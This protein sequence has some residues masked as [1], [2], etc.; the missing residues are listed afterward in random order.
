MALRR[1]WTKLV[2]NSSYKPPGDSCTAQGPQKQAGIIKI[3]LYI[4]YTISETIL[5]A[6]TLIVVA[7][8]VVNCALN[9]SSC[10]TLLKTVPFVFDHLWTQDS[11][12]FPLTVG[13]K[14]GP[15]Y[16]DQGGSKLKVC[17]FHFVFVF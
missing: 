8:I 5:Y 3:K 14:T 12:I 16:I 17:F 9:L 1:S 4:F 15:Y 6:Q 7:L 11:L 10:L 2:I 13:G